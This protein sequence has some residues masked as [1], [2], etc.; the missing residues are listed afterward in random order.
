[1]LTTPR[2]LA[3]AAAVLAVVVFGLSP[4]S[5]LSDRTA[6]SWWLAPPTAWAADLQTAIAEAGRRGFTCREQFVN[7]IGDEQPAT[8]SSTSTLFAAGNRYR[9]DSYEEGRW[10][11]TQWYVPAADGL[12]STSI[13]LADKTYT[14]TR[15]PNSPADA[16]DPL[17]RMLAMAEKLE[18]R[19]HAAR[20]GHDRRT[21]G[22]GV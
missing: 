1:M 17:A 11:E 18:A 22:G 14:V 5:A 4:W 15:D 16:D 12:T 9:R 19:R 8:S 21:R 13:R 2:S 7:R 3:V 20:H 6:G 10:R